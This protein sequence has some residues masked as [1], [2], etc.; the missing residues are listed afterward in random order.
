MPYIIN[1][2]NGQQLVI[3]Q[4]ASLDQTTDLVFV[5][6]NYSGY[7]EI[8]NENFL[9][10]LENFSNSTPPATPL[11]GQTW[12]NNTNNTLNLCYAEASGTFAAKFKTLAVSNIGSAAPIDA[13]IGDLWYDS[14]TSQLKVWSGSGYIVV[15]PITGADIRAQ[16]RGDFEYDVLAP[17]LP[18]YN[19]KAVIGTD[20]EVIAIVSAETYN[21]SEDYSVSP[22]YPTY[23]APTG[24]DPGFTHIRKGIT[25]NGADPIT[26]SSRNEITGLSTSSYFWGTAAESLTSLYANVAGSSSGI[27][28][29]TTATNAQFNVTFVDSATNLAYIDAGITYNPS[30]NILTTIASSALYADLAER[31]EADA[32]YEAGTVLVIGG[33][34]EVTVTSQFADTRVAGIVSKKPAYMMNS[35]AGTDETH[36]Y[37]ALKGRVPCKVVGYVEKG[38]LLVTSAH[39]GYAVAA[40]SVAAGSVI[41][42]ALEGNSEGFGVVEVLVV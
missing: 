35:G 34:K 29:R 40:K 15:G 24:G 42:K 16:W 38:D 14:S 39:P 32:E 10:L 33:N 21:M 11:V 9:K 25:L 13:A 37:I 28:T 31:Y 6:R 22:E 36:P 12:Y 17:D 4:D 1:K 27:S 23:T 30:S 2:T 3:V 20:D 41:G 7:G 5:G 26:G 19:I 18:V 8:Q